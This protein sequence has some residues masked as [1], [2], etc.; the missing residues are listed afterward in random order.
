MT[1][2]VSSSLHM[3]DEIVTKEAR[4]GARQGHMRGQA[5]VDSK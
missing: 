5:P 4:M 1:M 3:G 2:N